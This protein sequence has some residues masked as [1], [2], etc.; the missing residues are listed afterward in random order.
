MTVKERL[1]LEIDM[2]PA[3]YLTEVIDFIGYLK[4]KTAPP[5]TETMLLSEKP[6]ADDWN[7]AEEDKAW[8]N[9]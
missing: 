9:L 2:L 5:I 6:L 1:Q 7:T 4:T 8:N 3:A